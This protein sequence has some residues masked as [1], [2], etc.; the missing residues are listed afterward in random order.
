LDSSFY[1]TAEPPATPKQLPYDPSKTA[2]HTPVTAESLETIR[3]SGSQGR[4]YNFDRTSPFYVNITHRSR[5]SK[6]PKFGK[7]DSVI[8]EIVI[9][10]PSNDIGLNDNSRKI[11]INE[12]LTKETLCLLN[13]AKLLKREHEF[14][15]VWPKNGII[16]AR[17][18]ANENCIR[19]DKI[20][21][22]ALL[23]GKN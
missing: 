15:F 20:E 10:S 2:E 13:N 7:T 21:D 17:K 18:N 6:S 1:H 14:D 5:S 9:S 12:Y 4:V 11:Y 23:I 22:I 8:P 19:I 3:F 16:Y